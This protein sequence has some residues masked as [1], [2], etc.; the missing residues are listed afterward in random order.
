MIDS[1]THTR[2]SKHAV[3]SVDDL[4]RA[5]VI[6]GIKILTIT[7]HAPFFVDETNRLLESELQAYFE[8]IKRAKAK[9]AGAIKILTGLELD[10]MPGA[11]DYLARILDRR[12]LDFL[13]GSIHYIP[14]QRGHVK[15]WDLPRLND[16]EVLA[17][18]FKVLEEL[19]ACGLFD[20]VGHPDALLRT[21]PDN[22]F[23][24]RLKPL[25]PLFVQHQVAYELNA[26][27]LRKATFDLASRKEIY[28]VWSYPSRSALSQLIAEGV[29]FTIGSDAHDPA[30]AGAGIQELLR[31]LE[32]DGVRNV[33][34][35]ENRRHVEV[36]IQDI[37]TGPRKE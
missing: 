34:Y 26:S 20:A 12:D 4:V 14:V 18:Y 16:P 23:C 22:V 7:D 30:D 13:I 6:N 27:G 25:V 19:L 11:Y 9:Y 1:H 10:Y 24:E 3:G 15:V 2:Y 8:D 21:V 31:T 29:H 33:S 17:S 37:L 5:A 32:Q 28:G 35:F 36:A